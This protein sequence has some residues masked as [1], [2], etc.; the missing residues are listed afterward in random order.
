MCVAA[1]KSAPSDSESPSKPEG[2]ATDSLRVRTHLLASPD[3]HDALIRATRNRGSSASARTRISSGMPCGPSRAEELLVLAACSCSARPRGISPGPDGC[4]A[5]TTSSVSASG[6]RRPRS[7]PLSTLPRLLGILVRQGPAP[8]AG[9]PVAPSSMK[10]W[11][12]RYTAAAPISSAASTLSG[13]FFPEPFNRLGAPVPVRVC[14]TG[15]STAPLQRHSGAR[16]PGGGR[17]RRGGYPAQAS[18][19]L[20]LGPK[21]PTAPAGKRGCAPRDYDFGVIAPRC[22]HRK[23]PA[24]CQWRASAPPGPRAVASS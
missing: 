17:V 18:L 2:S 14:V 22:A 13:H 12:C 5:S 3:A 24:Q 16:S 4:A 20:S 1:P 19:S 11:R 9:R 15:P 8:C 10:T 21:M 7:S 23:R 6:K